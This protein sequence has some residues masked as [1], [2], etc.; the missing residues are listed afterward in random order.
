[1]SYKFGVSYNCIVD[2]INVGGSDDGFYSLDMVGN[3]VGKI[4]AYI[5]KYEQDPDLILVLNDDLYIGKECSQGGKVVAYFG[6]DYDGDGDITPT[7]IV[8]EDPT[9]LTVIE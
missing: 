4:T 3:D 1:M 5:E 6:Y 9:S 2:D 7:I 8:F